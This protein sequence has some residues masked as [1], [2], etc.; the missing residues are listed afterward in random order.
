VTT[1]S[2]IPDAG[3]AERPR[4][5]LA[6]DHP[7]MLAL[8]AAVLAGECF[9]VGSVVDG[10]ALLAEA[11]RL[12]PDV[13]VLDI[14]MPRLDGIEAARQLHRSQRPARL[15]FLTVHE[16]ADFARAALDAG[17]LGYVVKARLASDLLPAIRAALADRRFISPTISLE[18]NA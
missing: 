1:A 18:E 9:V 15:V 2:S 4:V 12:H 7:A 5:L 16:D 10:R 6:D 3:S 14:T 8:T 17:G 13:I 11:E